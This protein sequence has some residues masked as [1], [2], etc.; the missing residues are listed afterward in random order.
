MSLIG[1]L[2]VRIPWSYYGLVVNRLGKRKTSLLDVGCGDGGLM[3]TLNDK[4]KYEVTGVDIFGPDLER[5]RKTGA[6]KRLV[7][8]DIRKMKFKDDSFDVVFSA[9]VVEHLMKK[10][11]LQLLKKM[12]EIAREKVIIITPIGKKREQEAHSGNKYQE[13]KSGWL[14]KDF[15]KKGYEVTGQGLRVYYENKAINKILGKVGHLN[16]LIFLLHVV[17]QPLLAKRFIGYAHQMICVKE[18][19]KDKKKFTPLYGKK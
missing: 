16:N 15:S 13:H 8:S 2:S 11:G 7:K 14:P 18:K 17:F 6:Y 5:A 1:K 12:E 3:S 9:H 19:K 10:D 4:R